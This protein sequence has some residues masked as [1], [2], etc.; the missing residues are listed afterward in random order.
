[1]IQVLK[2]VNGE[3]VIARVE[4][5]GVSGDIYHKP[6]IFHMLQTENGARAALIPYILSAPDVS[7]KIKPEAIMTIVEAPKQ[8]EDAYLQQTSGIDLTAASN[9]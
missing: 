8:M 5:G 3:E 1:M 2:L 7:V 9:L 4:A 6:R